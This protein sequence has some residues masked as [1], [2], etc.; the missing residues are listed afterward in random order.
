MKKDQLKLSQDDNIE[1]LTSILLEYPLVNTIDMNLDEK[2]YKLSFL[3]DDSLTDESWE[4]KKKL[5]EQ[6]FRLFNKLQKQSSEGLKLE[7]Y[8]YEVINKVMLTRDLEGASQKELDFIVSLIKRSFSG[9]LLEKEEN[10]FSIAQSSIDGLLDKVKDYKPINK[11]GLE[12]SGFREE[13]KI[14]VF[15]KSSNVD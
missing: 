11:V 6:N 8:N 9:K 7:R 4:K 2:W 5:I 12:Y 10:Y 15:D 1:L 3:I 13:G 14:M